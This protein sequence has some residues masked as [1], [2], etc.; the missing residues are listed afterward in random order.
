MKLNNNINNYLNKNDIFYF[1]VDEIEIYWT[2]SNYKEI[3]KW[4]DSDNS[5]YTIFHEFT[6]KKS[7][8]LRDYLFKVDFFKDNL[9]CFA[10]YIWKQINKKIKTR[11]YFKV[12]WSAFQLLELNEIIDFVDTYIWLDE[13]DIQKWNKYNTLKR[14][15]LAVDIKKHLW[16]EILNNFKELKQ[17][18]TK[19]YWRNWSI[20]TYYIWEYQVKY[21]KSFLIRIYDKIKDIKKKNKQKLYSHYINEKTEITRIE[22]EFRTEVVKY[23]KLEQLLDRSYIFN[24]FIR[25]IE[26]HTKL[27][28]D[29]KNEEVPKLKRLNKKVDLERLKEDEV[30]LNNY[31]KVFLWYSKRILEIWYCPV[32]ILFAHLIVL[33]KT[34][35]K[36]NK[37]IKDWEFN[38]TFFNGIDDE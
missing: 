24:L 36:I 35:D 16:K 17:K 30:L 15:D 12:Y 8:K 19:Y 7:D 20:E 4:L 23:L 34:K 33:E 32:K 5:D 26:K 37:S 21:N 14:F 29:L 2:F 6:L 27:F 11:D 10:F 38:I 1:N 9:P 3:L 22:I 18:G 28:E 31:I 25:Y 13:V